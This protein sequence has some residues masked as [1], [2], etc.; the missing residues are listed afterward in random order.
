MA[1]T[2]RNRSHR[3]L[4]LGGAAALLVLASGAYADPDSESIYPEQSVTRTQADL[5][6][7]VT[8]EDQPFAYVVDASTASQGVVA[9]GYDLGL[10]SGISAIRPIPVVLQNEGIANGFTLSYGATNWLEP[11]VNLIVT[12]NLSNNTSSVDGIAGLK[13]QLTSPDSP[14]RAAVMGGGLREGLSQAFGTWVRGIGSFGT[15]PLL[16]EANVYVEHVFQAGRDG[17]D[18]MATLGADYRVLPF[19]RVGAEWVGQDLEE[20]FDPGDEG[21]SR[22]GLGPNVAFDLDRGRYQIVVT[23]LFGLN[24]IS[25]TAMVRA[26]L[27]GSF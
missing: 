10:G 13:V 20:T 4:R 17:A 26:G 21:G 22:M 14:W 7:R 23:G 11:T 2:R 3:T 1:T 9:V 25:P 12:S 19:M 5:E 6:G 18:F 27:L 15:G 24:A 8:A 16:V